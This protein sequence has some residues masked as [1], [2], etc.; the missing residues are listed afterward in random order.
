MYYEINAERFDINCYSEEEINKVID[1]ALE[2]IGENKIVRIKI[3]DMHLNT[4][5]TREAFNAFLKCKRLR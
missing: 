1:L 3:G 4:F 2:A 5:K